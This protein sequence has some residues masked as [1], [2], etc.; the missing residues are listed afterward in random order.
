MRLEKLATPGFVLGLI[1]LLAN[2]FVLKSIFHNA[3]TGKL[4]DFA[5]IFIFPLFW[6]AVFPN[7]KIFIYILTA[8]IFA[9][10]KSPY[11]QPLI[12]I[13]NNLE[14]I[15]LNRV[16]DYTD[17]LALL[18]LP[19]SYYY[20]TLPI[21]LQ[22]N[23][24]AHCLL[25]LMSLFAFL[26]T[27]EFRKSNYSKNKFYEFETPKADLLKKIEK[28]NKECSKYSA[29][30]SETEKDFEIIICSRLCKPHLGEVTK[31]EATITIDNNSSNPDGASIY[32][33]KI[34][35]LDGHCFSS[36]PKR[37]DKEADYEER[38]RL[39][40]HI[41]EKEIID[42]LKYGKFED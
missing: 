41:F 7:K 38:Q 27:S 3:F 36:T 19:F 32:V 6:L 20:D 21:T 35:S 10:W 9:F 37:K 12:E 42:R 15:T 25:M 18:I 5:G 16:V 30:F 40:D 13:W 26:A 24:L 17:L 14:V 31:I 23:R 34:Y 28:I 22:A 4:S 33:K 11:S 1:L 8:C 39:L 29:P 2:D